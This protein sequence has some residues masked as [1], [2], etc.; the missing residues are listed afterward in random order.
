VGSIAIAAIVALAWYFIRVHGRRS[1]HPPP[2]IGDNYPEENTGPGIDSPEKTIEAPTSS[3]PVA[4]APL[5]SGRIQY[6][7]D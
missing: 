4:S 7:M 5:H 6:G 1:D 2:T 3:S